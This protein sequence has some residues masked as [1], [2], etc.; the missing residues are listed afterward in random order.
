M[1]YR[2]AIYWAPPR[3]HPLWREGCAWLG[4]DPETG[5]RIVP[6]MPGG[7]A[8]QQHATITAEPARYGWHGTLKP[9]FRLADGESEASLDAALR[10]FAAA[11]AP[12]DVGRLVVRPLS[13]FLA[14]V[15]A[16]R[17]APLD[18]LAAACVSTF[19]AFRAPPEPGEVARRQRAGLTP[20]QQANLARWG[21]PYVMDEFRFHL[22][23]TGRLAMD[24]AAPLGEVLAARFSGALAEPIRVEEVALYVEPAPGAPFILRRRYRFG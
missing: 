22:T 2:Y 20:G 19:D 6:P 7:M 4:R 21:Y 14:V 3:G 24:E 15:P 8:E 11:Q 17:S 23:L 12:F 16:E 18:A 1:A 10:A 5:E 13:G 9:P